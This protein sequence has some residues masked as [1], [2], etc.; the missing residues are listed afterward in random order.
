[1]RVSRRT[2]RCV[3]GV[4]PLCRVQPRPLP[5]RMRYQIGSPCVKHA[6]L[7]HAAVLIFAQWKLQLH[8]GY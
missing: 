1:M 7:P 3:R 2:I 5:C 8:I 6:L 4:P